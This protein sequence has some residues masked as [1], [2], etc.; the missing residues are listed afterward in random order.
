MKIRGYRIELGE[1]EATLIEHP[2]VKE[3]VVLARQ[4]RPGDQRLVAY[5]VAEG[6]EPPPLPELRAF[7]RRTLPD[8]MVPSVFV[9]LEAMPL[10][11]NGK[12]D[13]QA[14]PGPEDSQSTLTEELV[15]PRTE[16]EHVVAGIW[17]EVLGIEQV[18]VHDNFFDLGGHSLL[19]TRVVSRVRDVFGLDIPIRALFETGNLAELST[20]IETSEGYNTTSGSNPILNSLR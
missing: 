10:T 6:K 13:R 11:P 12:V 3:T 5:V 16:T 15:A 20:V 18:G 7:A 17:A 2:A 14:L 1:I 19:A 4:D 9:V 8:Y